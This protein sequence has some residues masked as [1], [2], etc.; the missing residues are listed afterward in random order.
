MSAEPAEFS[1]AWFDAS[2]AAW[3]ANKRRIKGGSFRYTCDHQYSATRR[4]GRD[5]FMKESFCRQHY[6]LEQN[7]KLKAAMTGANAAA[8]LPPGLPNN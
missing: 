2:S 1:P 8:A 4:C 6:H 5:V 7:R 3:L